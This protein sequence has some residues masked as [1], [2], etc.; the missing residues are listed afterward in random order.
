MVEKERMRSLPDFVAT[1]PP[2]GRTTAAEEMAVAKVADN[3]KAMARTD[4]KLAFVIVYI[5]SS[6]FNLVLAAGES[7]G[8]KDF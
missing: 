6:V 4:G 1:R 8:G 3:S 7:R 2:G 5:R